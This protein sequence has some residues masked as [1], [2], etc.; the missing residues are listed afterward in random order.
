MIRLFNVFCKLKILGKTAK[1][2]FD[3][4]M[5]SF[6]ITDFP[7]P[8]CGSRHPNW[9]FFDDY[10]RYLISFSGG[11]RT[12]ELVTVMRYLCSSCLD[13]HA[14]I[15]EIAIPYSGYSIFFILD[16]L[17]DR[18]I[19]KM[20]IHS[21]CQKYIISVST[22]YRWKKLYEQNKTLWLGALKDISTDPGAFLEEHPSTQ[23]SNFLYKFWLRIGLSFLQSSLHGEE[24]HPDIRLHPPPAFSPAPYTI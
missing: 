1:T 11:K 8:S 23:T 13:T 16:V 6:D 12:D 5:A 2:L 22:F 15:P 7:C 20:T 10:E 4:A 24:V 19:H 9:T 17:R 3:E 21:I 18:F 14:I